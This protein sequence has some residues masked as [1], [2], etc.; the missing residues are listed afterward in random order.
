[1]RRIALTVGL[2]IIAAIGVA[3]AAIADT[4]IRETREE[5]VPAGDHTIASARAPAVAGRGGTE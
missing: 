2:I 5:V 1:M 4:P 3:P